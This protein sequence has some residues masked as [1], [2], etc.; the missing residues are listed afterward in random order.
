MY[1]T[2]FLNHFNALR[3]PRT[4][5]QVPRTPRPHV[6]YATC[7]S[8][9]SFA[10]SHETRYVTHETH[11]DKAQRH[12]LNKLYGA[13]MKLLFPTL[14]FALLVALISATTANAAGCTL[15][16]KKK[17]I[18][19]KSAYIGSTPIS[20]RVQKALATKCK[21]SIQMMTFKEQIQYEQEKSKK[22]IEKLK[23]QMSSLR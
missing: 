17:S 5:D 4:A 3:Y 20:E 22:R 6:H 9:I 13:T 8:Y 19:S 2:Y 14:S 16:L 1:S 11:S 10:T 18:T 15:V 12:T 21:V 23:L 7:K